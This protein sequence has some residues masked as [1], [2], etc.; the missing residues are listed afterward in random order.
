MCSACMLLCMESVYVVVGCNVV[1]CE[2][3]FLLVG[4]CSCM[5]TKYPFYS[6]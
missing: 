5:V 6:N 2:G 3:M 1:A 4:C